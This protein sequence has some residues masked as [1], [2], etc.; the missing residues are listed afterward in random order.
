VT[1]REKQEKLVAEIYRL[2]LRLAKL[3]EECE[4]T[5][6]THTSRANTGHYDPSNDHYWYENRCTDCGKFWITDQ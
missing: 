5:F 4:H 3:Q 2:Q 6:A 1:I